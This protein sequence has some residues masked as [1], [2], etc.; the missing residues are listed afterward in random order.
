MD[1]GGSSGGE[2]AN[3][4]TRGVNEGRA[5]EV[6]DGEELLEVLDVFG[7]DGLR[8]Y[9]LGHVEGVADA[10]EDIEG[11][12]GTGAV[13]RITG[14]ATTQIPVRWV[15]RILSIFTS[16]L[17]RAAAPYS[18][19]CVEGQ[20]RELRPE[21]VRRSSGVRSGPTL[22]ASAFA[23]SRW[24]RG[25]A[26]SG[27]V[28]TPVLGIVGN[29]D[30]G[31]PALLVDGDGGGRE[32]RV[33]EGPH[34]D[35]DLSFVPFFDV[36]DRRSAPRAEGEP[37]PSALVPDPDEL[38]AV[39]LHGHGLAGEAS[40]RAEDAAGPALAGVAVADGDARRFSAD[41]HPELTATARCN[42]NRHGD[43][44]GVTCSA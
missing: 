27:R 42:A 7:E 5:G 30:P 11:L 28:P 34:G 44:C 9:I 13:H 15:P 37:E 23:C 20:F 18:P 14:G 4:Y 8:S 38:R 31:V 6:L 17:F 26:S 21:G 10:M 1:T 29:G 3:L 2:N 22:P 41:L 36:E 32:A 39:A 40:L 12:R 43:S 25:G 24:P 33:R 35:G 16:P 19:E